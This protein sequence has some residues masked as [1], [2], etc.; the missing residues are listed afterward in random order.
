MKRVAFLLT[1]ALLV[2][3]CSADG[4]SPSVS[5]TS[6]ALPTAGQTRAS[7]TS[8][9]PT[10]TPV[11][12]GVTCPPVADL[13]VREFVD[14]DPACFQGVELT[15]RAWLDF[16]PPLGWEGPEIEPSWVAYPVAGGPAALWQAP[17]TGED[18]VCD[19]DTEP[20][21]AWFFAHLDPAAH[22]TLGT[23]RWIRVTGHI[24]DPAADACHYVPYEGMDDPLPDAAQAVAV[25]RAQ[26]VVTSIA[27][28]P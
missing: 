23:E 18:N 24:A 16:S 20:G 28:A 26:F 25:C 1:S 6:A 8:P 5:A 11:P 13:T 15:M 10:P 14:A 7:M 17:P 19:H 12:P 2:S 22:L 21:C 9:R 4:P 3:A 27:E